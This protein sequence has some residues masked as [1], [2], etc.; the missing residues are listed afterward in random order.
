MSSQDK[1][2]SKMVDSNYYTHKRS[3]QVDLKNTFTSSLDQSNFISLSYHRFSCLKKI[4]LNSSKIKFIESNDLS[5]HNNQI[6]IHLQRH[7]L[8]VNNFLVDLAFST[9]HILLSYGETLKRST[10]SLF[11]A[12]I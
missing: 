5:F 10:L 11:L 7:K 9:F 8:A 4:E 2:S 3:L 12:K 1:S 6:T